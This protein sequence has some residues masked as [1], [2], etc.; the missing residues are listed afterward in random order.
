M[1]LFLIS[2]RD[3]PGMAETRKAT[4]SAHLEWAKS[5]GEKMLMGG[6][7]VAEDG[8][9]MIGSSFVVEFDTLEA[10]QVWAANDP[11]AIAGMF[12]STEVI[13]YKWLL[14]TKKPE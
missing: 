3:K 2:G 8:D 14:G 10:A 4:R 11:Y 9:A 1:P 6:P 7:V 12:Q 5:V 13:E